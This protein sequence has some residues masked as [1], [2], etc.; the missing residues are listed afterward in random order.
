MPFLFSLVLI[1]FCASLWKELSYL[2]VSDVS[3]YLYQQFQFHIRIGSEV[4][5]LRKLFA[6]KKLS[7]YLPIIP[8]QLTFVN[9]LRVHTI[10]VLLYPEVVQIFYLLSEKVTKS[11]GKY[12]VCLSIHFRPAIIC[13]I[14][15]KIG[16]LFEKNT[17]SIQFC[18]PSFLTNW[19][20]P[21]L[22]TRD[23][24]LHL[25]VVFIRIWCL[26]SC[27]QSGRRTYP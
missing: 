1:V 19:M 26:K 14:P 9:S 4:A 13:F 6:R 23:N 18:S 10:Y 3:Y 7:I 11:I 2:V 27:L 22:Q 25:S 24:L 21:Q 20:R 17:I 12:L 15:I 5:N 16:E 8:T